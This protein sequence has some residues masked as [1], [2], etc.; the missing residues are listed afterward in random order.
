MCWC[1]VEKKCKEMT[2]GRMRIE[3]LLNR[4]NGKYGLCI[5][6][7]NASIEIETFFP[8]NIDNFL[9]HLHFVLLHLG[10][11]IGAT[12]Q[13]QQTTKQNAIAKYAHRKA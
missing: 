5:V 2:K 6:E 9:I 3:V 4:M 8:M 13:K 1:V 11:E 12:K 7:K 10:I